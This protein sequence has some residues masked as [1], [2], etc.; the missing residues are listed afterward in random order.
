MAKEITLPSGAT[1][2]L[3]NPE[4]LLKKDRDKVS[5]IASKAEGELMQAVAMQDAFIA[6]SVIEWSFDL[7]PPSIKI[8][9]L[10]ELTPKDYDALA[11]E[12]MKAVNYLFPSLDATEENIE[13]P[14]AD[15]ANSND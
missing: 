1:V 15:T 4:T 9:S 2:K 11:E 13:N 14:K 7:V 3:R 8:T 5:E 6:V 12:A 10:G